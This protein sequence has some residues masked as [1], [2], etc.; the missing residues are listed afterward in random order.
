MSR[1]AQATSQCNGG[2]VFGKPVKKT[3]LLA[4]ATL[5]FMIVTLFGGFKFLCNMRELDSKF[6]FE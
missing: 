1:P 6:I 3:H 4:N 2:I 5:N